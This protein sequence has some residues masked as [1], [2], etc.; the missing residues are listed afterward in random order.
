MSNFHFCLGHLQ[1]FAIHRLDRNET[2]F[3]RS[4]FEISKFPSNKFACFL[5]SIQIEKFRDE[6][7]FL[8]APP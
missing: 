5:G 4:A 3:N 8:I 1:S 7:L 6:A 2:T